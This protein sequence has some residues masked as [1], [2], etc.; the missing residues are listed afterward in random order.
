VN[1]IGLG[2]SCH[3][4]TEAIFQSLKG[5]SDVQQGWISSKEHPSFSEAVIVLFDTTIIDLA[6]LMD[7]HLRTHHSTSNHRMRKKYRSAIYAF[8]E[9]QFAKCTQILSALQTEFSKPLVTEVQHFDAFKLNSENYLD[10]Y[11]SNPNKPF[12]KNV[13]DPKLNQLRQHFGRWYDV[14]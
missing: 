7:I 10:Y 5:V 1:K 4:C 14:S 3:W 6:V 8:S 13:I 9:D 2:G 12:C 11:R